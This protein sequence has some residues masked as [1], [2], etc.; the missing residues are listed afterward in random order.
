MGAKFTMEKDF[1][2]DLLKD[3]YGITVVIPHK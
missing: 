1:Y 2:K 3:K